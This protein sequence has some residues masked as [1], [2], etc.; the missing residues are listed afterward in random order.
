MCRIVARFRSIDTVVAIVLVAIAAAVPIDEW[1]ED[2]EK[3]SGGSRSIF[4]PPSKYIGPIDKSQKCPLCEI[5]V[6]TGA[7]PES[8]AL[9]LTVSLTVSKLA[10]GQLEEHLVDVEATTDLLVVYGRSTCV[11]TRG[12]LKQLD[13]ASISYKFL[14]IDKPEG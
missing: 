4:F 3:N 14:R 11:I 2:Y 1:V 10:L 8:E 13:S 5:D 7:S 6:G 9:S 12:L